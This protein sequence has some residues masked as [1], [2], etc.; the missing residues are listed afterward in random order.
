VALQVEGVAI[1]AGGLRLHVVRGK[2][3]QAGQGAELGL[4]RGR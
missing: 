1:A 4:P 3:D 2:T